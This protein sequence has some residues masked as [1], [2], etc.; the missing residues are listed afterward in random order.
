[1]I[2]IIG[3]GV[4]GLAIA[5]EL[6]K[7]NR[8]V[9]VIERNGSFGRETSSRNSGTVHAGIYYPPGSLKAETCVAGNSQLYELCEHWNIPHRKTGKL[10]VAKEKNEIQELELLLKQGRENGATGLTM[11][12]QKQLNSIEP[13]IKA[14]AAI[15]SSS[16]G[17]ID[18]CALMSYFLAKAKENG[19]EI[20][21]RCNVIDVEKTPGGYELMVIESPTAG[22]IVRTVLRADIVI[23]CAGLDSDKIAGSAGIDD[24]SYRQYYCKGEYFSVNGQKKKLVKRLIYPLPE[25][26]NRGL[27]IHI[28]LNMEGKMLLGPDAV[29][30]NKIDYN[31]DESQREKFYQS[32]KE[33]LPFIEPDDLNPEM[34]GIRPKLQGPGEGFRDFIIKEE[35]DRGLP[36]FINL[37]GIESPGLTSSPAI[38]KYV[39]KMI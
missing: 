22:S 2:V 26:D 30:V 8:E 31:I 20:F 16:S 7:K 38:A 25:S 15:H 33:F 32:A 37:I 13:E 17:I 34:A 1:M 18:P 29:Y 39:A 27:G 3:A 9:C 35:S 28:V 24:L 11:V 5:S 10:I 14:T 4:I 21:Y 12:S 6:S 19:A 36:G 23:N